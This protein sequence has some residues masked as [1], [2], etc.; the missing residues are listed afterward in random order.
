MEM[1]F[2][3]A[4]DFQM[5]ISRIQAE[6]LVHRY[7]GDAELPSSFFFDEVPAHR[8]VV[9]AFTISKY[10][11]TNA[12]FQEFVDS[13]GYT[14]QEYWRELIASPD[15]NTDTTGWERIKLFKDQTGHTGPKPWKNGK[16]PE[17]KGAHPVQGISWFEAVA[18][19]RW[20]KLRLPTEAEWEFA[21]RGSD[22]RLFPW[23]NDMQ[24]LSDWGKRQAGETT[25][26]GM[27]P[28]DRSPFG[29]MDQARNVGEW[30]ADTWRPYPDS[31]I[32][33]F[34]EISDQFGVARGGMYACANYQTGT[35]RREKRHR[36]NRDS[37]VGFR[38]AS[39]S[40][41]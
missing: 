8:V 9:S 13:G 31:P 33:K 28:D 10:E 6:E 30:V 4:G 37:G 14:R 19:C 11:T 38:C 20:K 7:F 24:V 36:M 25:P 29:V 18:Y 17:G 3:P 35:T 21:A 27:M 39:N 32:A 15:L 12:E 5:G 1:L 41:R 34:Q 16:F 22:Q 2:I 23:G 40:K 26:V